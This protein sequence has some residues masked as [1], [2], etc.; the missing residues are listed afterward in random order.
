MEEDTLSKRERKKLNREKGASETPASFNKNKLWVVGGIVAL[1]AG[2]FWFMYRGNGS[3]STPTET[4][5]VVSPSEV[6]SQDHTKGPEN[7]VVTLVEYG[8]FQC[9]ACAAFQPVVDQLAEEFKNDL[10]VVYRHFPLRSLHKNAQISSQ[11]SEAAADQGYFWEMYK[12]LYE[13]QKDWSEVRDPRSLFKEYASQLSLNV[14]QFESYMNGD[15]AKAKVN[16]DYDSGFAAGVDSTPTFY[17]NGEKVTPNP[18]GI[19]PFRQ[20]IQQAIDENKPQDESTDEG[21]IASPE[22]EI[23]PQL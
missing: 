18:Q 22:S 15:S 13:K 16:A 5:Q 10:R 14:E 19:E 12:V 11:A 3:P 9:P 2:I 23:T 20:L 8:D 6:S 1:A 21:A 7:A 4:P 17:I